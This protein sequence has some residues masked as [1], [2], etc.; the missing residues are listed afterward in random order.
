MP[1]RRNFFLAMFQAEMRDSLED[2]DYL[3]RVVESRFRAGE[4]T[5]YVY[6][7]NEAFLK[8]EISGLKDLIAFLE[9]IN[10]NDYADVPA[11]ADGLEN[12]LKKRARELDDPEA[13]YDIIK[14]KLKKVRGY[15]EQ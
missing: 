10:P 5:N 7:E 2:I 12:L 4:I 13:V 14:R 9:T 6:N 11:L 8:H 1:G 3:S 15:I